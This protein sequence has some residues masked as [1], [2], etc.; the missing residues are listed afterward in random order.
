[1]KPSPATEIATAP[2]LPAEAVAVA[3]AKHARATSAIAT[4]T[5]LAAGDPGTAKR[6]MVR[7]IG[8]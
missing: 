1:M 8:S 6:L 7:A 2:T 5:A 4:S 3:S